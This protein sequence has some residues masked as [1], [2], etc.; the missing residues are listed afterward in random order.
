VSVG[1]IVAVLIGALVGHRRGAR[2]ARV[3]RSLGGSGSSWFPLP[4]V[5][6]ASLGVACW[7]R[8]GLSVELFAYALLCAASIEHVVVDLRTR[9]LERRVTDVAGFGGFV[10]LTV[11]SLVDGD[12][13]AIVRMLLGAGVMLLVFVS[14]AAISRG[15]VG[16]GDVR[17]AP[18]LAVYLAWLGWRHLVIGFAA[19]F[20]IGGAVAAVML[21][22]GAAGRRSRVA[23]GPSLLVGAL[24][25]VF[26]TDGLAPVVLGD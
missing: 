23:F 11:A 1:G 8:F 26:A 6:G 14:L 5:A 21:V 3:A 16:G 25:G 2:G 10:L 18:A 9:R 13:G 7:N 17:L 24:V 22:T 4:L 19:A 20:V 15:G 12:G